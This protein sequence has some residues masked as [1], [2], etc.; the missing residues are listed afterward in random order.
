MHW[1]ALQAQPAPDGAGDAEA[2][3]ADGSLA[4]AWWALQFTPKVTRQGTAVLLEVS[5]SERLLGGRAGL[6]QRLLAAQPPVAVA[7][8]T[9]AHTSLLALAL[10]RMGDAQAC[11][12]DRLP[13]AALDAAQEHLPTLK[14]LGCTCWGELRALPRGGVVRRF[15]AVLLHALDRAYGLQP[16]VYPWIALPDVFDQPLELA[17]QVETAPVLVFAANRL[18]SQLRVWLQARQ[19]GVLA[20][21]LGWEMDARRNTASH[22]KLLLRT[23][24]PTRDMQHL[25]RL[26]AEHLAHT[27]L[28]APVLYVR[29][30]SVQTAEL[31]VASSSLLADDAL[32]GDSLHQLLERLGAR[33]GA[34]HVRRVRPHADHR[35]EAMETWEPASG[36]QAPSTA[37][38]PAGKA[39]ARKTMERHTTEASL[40]PT[41][42]LVPPLEL[43]EADN[44]PLY[45]G[46]LTLLSRQQRIESAWW[47][48]AGFTP[49]QQAAGRPLAVLRDYFLARSET[50][51]LV[52]IYRERMTVAEQQGGATQKKKSRWFLHGVFG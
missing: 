23:A 15:G 5:E 40:Y 44:Q 43:A 1:I 3:L 17:S 49:G 34:D 18:L 16:D 10:L 42:L 12:P 11:H 8:A 13:L 29:L 51:G 48:V 4:L 9:Q 39:G 41:W 7:H 47:D 19:R 20:L 50:A 26:L 2:D 31:A 33:L 37:A 45:Q 24:Q 14:R 27:T 30:R 46:R 21:E 38:L 35:P 28:P 32:A 36:P 22:G 25:Q 52:W 6:L